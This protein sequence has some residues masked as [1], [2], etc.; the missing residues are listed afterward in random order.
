[1]YEPR[2]QTLRQQKVCGK[3]EC[4]AWRRKQAWRNWEI[5]NPGL[6]QGNR[7][8]QK[9]WREEHPGYWK[10]WRAKHPAYVKR[11]RRLQKRRDDRRRGNLAKPNGWIEEKLE[12]IDEV[13]RLKML[14]KPNGWEEVAPYQIDGICEI[15]KGV[16][17]LAKPNDMDK[18]G[19]RMKEYAA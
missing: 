18:V 12:K 15:L 8:K 16:V 7:I 19:G 1:M 14:A 11:N 6:G 5:K 9:K 2:P 13:R 17:L 4:K 3:A 10:G